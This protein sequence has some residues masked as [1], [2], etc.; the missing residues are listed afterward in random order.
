MLFTVTAV[1]FSLL[2]YEAVV[3]CKTSKTS[4]KTSTR[5]LWLSEC[6]TKGDEFVS[7]FNRRSWKNNPFEILENAECSTRNW[8]WKNSTTQTVYAD[9]SILKSDR[10]WANCPAGYFL[11]NMKGQKNSNGHLHNIEQG[12]CSKPADHPPYYGHCEHV[13]ISD[14]SKN[15]YLCR[16]NNDYYVAGIYRG[17]YNKL[18]CLEKLRCCKTAGGTE[19]L[20][21]LYKVKTRIMDT[22]MSDM[23]NLA[24]YMGYGWC[25]GCRAEYVGEDF[26]RSGDIW[27]ADT[28]GR[29]EGVKSY[30]RLKMAYGDWSFGIK[31][32]KYGTPVIQDLTPETI[33]FGTIY[34][35]DPTDATKIMT[36]YET[37]VRSVTHTTTS[38]WKNSDELN[39]QVS[40]TPPS[41][42]GGVGVSVGYKFNYETSTTT[43]DETK[44]EQSKN[45]LVNTE[46]TFKPKSASKWSLVLSKTRTSVTYTA[47]V[48]AKFTCELQGFLRW[49]GGSHGRYTNYHY[50]Y[51]GSEKRPTFHYRFGDSSIPFY[52]ALKR[53]SETNSQPWLWND[54]K[55]AHP[56]AQNLIDNLCNESRYIFKITG[57][58]DD[59]I[60]K[61][62][63]F[64]WEP[65]PL[66]K[67]SA[68][69][70]KDVP[71]VIHQNSTHVAMA[72]PNDVPLVKLEPPKVN[73]EVVN[74]AKIENL[75]LTGS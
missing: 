15:N 61:H 35:N 3:G 42:T 8:P 10:S 13:I 41:A 38:S 23:A 60:G 43:S 75:E 59:V 26:R 65:A 11:S 5:F 24:H 31:D 27:K 67:R 71:D 20:D 53:L 6:R 44:K 18:Y 50:Q 54:I 55:N 1:L 14:C 56:S 69:R 34:N 30:E 68:D 25:S 70:G 74:Q 45:F 36:R 17:T 21:E 52:T 39:V 33:D 4:S 46:K 48:I 37:S 51:L 2:A 62:A 63:E 73:I 47:T 7:G 49:G 28:S 66:R 12:I 58:F 9:W 29:C 64:Q 57:R 72:L 32:I 19:E 40:Y 22:T 16:C